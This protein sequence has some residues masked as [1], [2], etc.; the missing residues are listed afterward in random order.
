MRSAARS[1]VSAAL[2]VAGGALADSVFTT[3]S[4]IPHFGHFPG[5][6]ETTSGC[7]GQA[8]FAALFARELLC[9][10]VAVVCE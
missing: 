10:L 5:R 6:R 1:F 9:R 7:I 4:F 8:Y 2:D 3:L